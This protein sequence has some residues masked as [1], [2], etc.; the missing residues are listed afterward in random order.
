VSTSNKP[1]RQETIRVGNP[2]FYTIYKMLE[3]LS[4][5]VARIG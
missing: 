4:K 2:A 5:S 3:N 1:A